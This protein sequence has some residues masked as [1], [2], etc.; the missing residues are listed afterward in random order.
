M[1]YFSDEARLK[2]LRKRRKDVIKQFKYGP[3]KRDV[4]M[5]SIGLSIGMILLAFAGLTLEGEKLDSGFYLLAIIVFPVIA[6]ILYPVF[7]WQNK[8]LVLI[9]RKEVERKIR[10]IKKRKRHKQVK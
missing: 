7:Y 4:A 2:R 6:I 3:S 10:K 5:L 8:Y 1:K 9:I